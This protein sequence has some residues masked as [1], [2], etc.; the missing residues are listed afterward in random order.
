MVG[1]IDLRPGILVHRLCRSKAALPDERA[2]RRIIDGPHRVADRALHLMPRLDR[3]LKRLHRRSRSRG[4]KPAYLRVAQHR[5]PRVG[6]AV[7]ESPN[8]KPL[9][10]KTGAH[11]NRS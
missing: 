9:R 7:L 10:L 5:D 8:D 11:E 3:A 6:V 4:K 1:E 2:C